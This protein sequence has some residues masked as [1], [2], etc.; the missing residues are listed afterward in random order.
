M[1]QV[2]TNPTT[3]P[4]VAAP[5]LR[6]LAMRAAGWSTLGFG[7]G[8]VI[9]LA[10]NLVLTRLLFPEAFG[11]MAMV[12]VVLAGLQLFSDVGIGPS[13]IR[14]HALDRSFLATAWTIQI[15]RGILL[16]LFAV[17]L[18]APVAAYYD[19][20]ALARL[21][22]V[23]ALT[24]L[25]QGFNATSLFTAQ[26]E[27]ALGRLT[28]LEV[29]S[30]VLAVVVMIVWALVHPTVWAL[31]V[32]ALV[33]T[34]AKMA[35]SHMLLSGGAHGLCFD[36]AA[37]RE[38]FGFGKWIFI[39]TAITF[40]S[41][42]GDRLLLGKW[43]DQAQLGVYTIAMMLAMLP[44]ELVNRLSNVVLYPAVS[45]IMR[46]QRD[47]PARIARARRSLIALTV[48]LCALLVAAGPVIVDVL[49]DQR[50]ADA[51]VLLSVLSLG[52][53]LQVLT[54]TYGCIHLA[55]GKPQYVSAAMTVRTVLLFALAWPA[56]THYG[57]IGVAA[58]V[59]ASQIG[60]LVVV[61]VG[62]ARIGLTT[63]LSDLAMT[64]AVAAASL[65]MWAACAAGAA[66]F[67][68]PTPGLIAAIVVVAP[69]A[70]RNVRTIL[71]RRYEST[72]T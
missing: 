57:V 44:R 68:H 32:G 42:Q 53:W 25:I 11:V 35:L 13:I 55:D 30:H 18:S 41:M 58:V 45:R 61:A 70:Y 9:R 51:G 64:A 1:T 37:A 22:P 38:L 15:A 60:A 12:M 69:F 21:L 16:W 5:S 26:R 33:R 20:P 50:Y 72:S 17:A 4:D 10:G 48:P 40:V 3:S 34:V 36:R 66:W 43:I 7:A 56:F 54:T 6:A 49:Y 2:L 27:M 59:S 29:G 8:Q 14:Q 62:A 63:F 47:V 24:A 71:A 19:M 46:E 28:L 65:L 23:A 67:G 52:I 31:V 39:S